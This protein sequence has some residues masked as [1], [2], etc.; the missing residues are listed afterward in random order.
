MK[1]LYNF[2]VGVNF[3]RVKVYRNPSHVKAN[4]AFLTTKM[5]KLKSNFVSKSK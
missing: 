4:L 5:S 3:V 1:Y 2:N